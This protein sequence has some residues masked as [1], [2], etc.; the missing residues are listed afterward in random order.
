MNNQSFKSAKESAIVLTELMLPSYSNFS[1]KIHGGFILSL[2]DKAAF[3]TAT[4]FSSHY[5]VTASVNRVDFLNPIEVGEL[6]TLK[7]KVNYVGNSSMV[8]GIR[9]ISQ[10]IMTGEKKHCNSSYFSMVAKDKNG[11]NAKVPGLVISDQDDLRRF[12]RS[13]EHINNRNVRKTEFSRENFNH[14]DYISMLKNH[15][16]KIEI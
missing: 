12:L 4:K 3:T 15:N 11:K 1:G 14:G 6:V 2:M 8:V 9:V 7:A 13:I 10:N 5:C 16:V